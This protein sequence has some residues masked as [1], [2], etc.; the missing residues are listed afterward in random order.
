MV[1]LMILLD[2]DN[3]RLI[4]AV[5]GELVAVRLLVQPATGYCY[6]VV[7]GAKKVLRMEGTATV[8]SAGGR[9]GCEELQAFQF[10]AVAAGEDRLELHYRRPFGVRDAAP[11]KLFRVFVHVEPNRSLSVDVKEWQD[12]T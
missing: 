5:V 8:G 4:S 7:E 2:Q 6:E 12:E 10:R 3:G 1:A 11:L 9:P